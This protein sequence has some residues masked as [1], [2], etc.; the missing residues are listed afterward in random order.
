MK[1]PSA[2]SRIAGYKNGKIWINK[3]VPKALRKRLYR[4][5]KTELKL[6]YKGLSYKQAHKHA[7][8]AEH[9]GMTRKQI[10][11]YEGKLGAISRWYPVKRT[12]TK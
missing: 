4:H 10:A 5:E 6:R 1:K 11:K 3:K 7:L 8:K 2:T 12:R 9:K